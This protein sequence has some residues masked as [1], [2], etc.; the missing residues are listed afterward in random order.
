[1]NRETSDIGTSLAGLSFL[2]EIGGLGCSR[3]LHR[4]AVRRGRANK[5]TRLSCRECFFFKKERELTPVIK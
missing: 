2:L 3:F 4:L 5:K 1:V